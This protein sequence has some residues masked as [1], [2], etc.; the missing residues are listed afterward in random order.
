MPLIHMI[1]K[2]F[3]W[4][5][6]L[7][8]G[9]SVLAVAVYRFVPV[10]VTP[11]MLIRA[12]HPVGSDS[13]Q[14]MQRH[15]KHDWV[16][17]DRMS[18]WM[19]AAV[20]ASEDNRFYTHHGFDTTEIKKAME[21]SRNGGRQRGAS[22]ISQQTAKNVFLWPGHSWVRKG[23]EA[24][25]TVLI[26]LM[27]PKERIMEVYLNSIEMG[28]G[29]YGAEAAAEHYFSCPAEDLSKR[30]CA[31]IAVSLPNPIK[32]NP[33]H[34]TPYLNRRASKIMRYMAPR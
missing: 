4:F 6:L 30:Q 14:D 21:E 1:R 16:P 25:F 34:P 18:K 28:A 8:F 15:W 7:F 9:S 12:V 17:L 24:Y 11:L 32:R 10:K 29:I 23:L 20:V 2:I 27:W 26:E 22:T 3:K 13:Q 19:A 33:A 5:V 31:L